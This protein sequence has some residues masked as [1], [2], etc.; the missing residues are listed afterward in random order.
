M[1]MVSLSTSLEKRTKEGWSAPATPVAIA[2][3]R[4]R[5]SLAESRA[6][7]GATREPAAAPTDLS[8]AMLPG[9]PRV[10]NA[11]KKA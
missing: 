3:P 4:R 1:K 6:S 8:S 7:S 2:R 9:C 10:A 11:M 5:K